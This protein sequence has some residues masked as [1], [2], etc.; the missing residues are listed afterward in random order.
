MGIFKTRVNYVPH[1]FNSFQVTGTHDGEP[2]NF[3]GMNSFAC[4]RLE[5]ET[6]PAIAADG[7]GLFQENPNI[8]GTFTIEIIEADPT[9]KWLWDRQV[10]GQAFAVSAVDSNQEDLECKGAQV[11]VKKAPVVNKG[12]EVSYVEWTLECIY[13]DVKSGGYALV[14]A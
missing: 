8:S 5:D 3:T 7:V 9:N 2:Y 11:R 13:L 4:E 10:N 6:S 12:L 1:N 14:A